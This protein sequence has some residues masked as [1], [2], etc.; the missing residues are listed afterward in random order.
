[1]LYE[2]LAEGSSNYSLVVVALPFIAGPATTVTI[3]L[4]IFRRYRNTD[5]RYIFERES[6]VAVGNLRTADR[7]VGENNRQK[8]SRMSS[9]NQTRHLTRVRRIRVP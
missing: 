9:A 1:M 5:K 8:S 3:Y 2:L 4:A 7:K 6:R